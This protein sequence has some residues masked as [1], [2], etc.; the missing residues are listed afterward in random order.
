M[1]Y[2]DIEELLTP[3]IKKCGYYH[4]DSPLVIPQTPYLRYK[5]PKQYAILDSLGIPCMLRTDLRTS[6]LS[7]YVRTPNSQIRRYEFGTVIRSSR[8]NSYTSRF[9][10]SIDNIWIQKYLCY[11]VFRY[12]ICRPNNKELSMMGSW[13]AVIIAC[14]ILRSLSNVINTPLQL[15]INHIGV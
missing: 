3:I 9:S 10:A 13:E 7:Y 15:H 1:I 11:F 8:E 12:Y 5:Y 6:F 2:N 14:Q 4:L